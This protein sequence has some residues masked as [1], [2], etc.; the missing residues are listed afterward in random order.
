M[1]AGV[2]LVGA[3]SL[4][5]LLFGPQSVLAFLA[6]VVAPGLA[7]V[8][9][10]PSQ[11]SSPSIR[12]A[13]VPILGL[14]VS[15]ISIITLSAVG[16]PLTATSIR[17]LLLALTIV[18]FVGSLSAR[19]RPIQ[20]V[21]RLSFSEVG[22]LVLLAAAACLAVTLESLVVGATPLPGQDWG[23]YLLYADEIRKQH[24]ILI[25]NPYWMLGGLPFPDDP[26]MPSLYAAFGLLTDDHTAVLV[27]G[28][29]VIAALGVLAVFICAAVLWGRVAG[30]IAAGLYAAVPMNLD[31]LAWHGLA[32]IYGLALLPLI[33]LGLAMGLRG[34]L[35]RRWAA[36]LAI[37][38]IALAAAHRLTFMIAFTAFALTAVCLLVR[39]WRASIHFLS[40]TAAFSLTIGGGVI[41]ELIHQKVAIGGINDD[42]HK[43]LSTKVD[44]TLT[45][46]DL[47]TAFG[48]TGALALAALLLAPPI[49]RDPA[50][51][52]FVALFLGILGFSYAWIAHFPWAYNRAPYYLPL[53]LSVAVGAAWAASLPRWTLIGAVA[54][55][56]TMSADAR[57]LAPVYRSFYG[58]A[59]R[60][61]L[62]GLEYVKKHSGSNEV[63]VTDTCWGF[64]SPWLL[65]EQ[66]IA[67]QDPELIFPKAEVGPAE[68]ARR[69][70]YGGPTGAILAQRLNARY[71]LI[72]PLCTHQT[73]TPVA[74]PDVGRPVFASTRLIVLDLR[75]G[76][77][78]PR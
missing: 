28:I 24:S 39:N 31:M 76:R 2:F 1:A 77:P 66:V 27:Q 64:L 63:V 25:D 32:S 56:V 35:D 67:A 20:R 36:F 74:P 44:W 69:I 7:V 10:L 12:V 60:G 75:A 59:N 9:L 8:P 57:D 53:L 52:V 58:Y 71:A 73:G 4:V 16:V 23:H 14:A 48:V 17:L 33:L 54:L 30:L 45:G 6:L 38:F 43:F 46:R 41:V 21:T 51:L 34:H 29:W 47:T 5:N 40:W 78:A 68:T 11:L 61:S 22:T 19:V 3:E 37:A 49:R 62:T 70:L 55:I 42:F 65:G 72:D 15:S 50:R 18:L 26:G 13:A